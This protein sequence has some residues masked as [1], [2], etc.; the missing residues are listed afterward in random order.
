[1][2]GSHIIVEIP[3]YAIKIVAVNIDDAQNTIFQYQYF[4]A[5]RSN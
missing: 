5:I 2:S 3:E 4:N 1:M